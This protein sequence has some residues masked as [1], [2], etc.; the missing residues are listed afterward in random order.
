M[1]ITVRDLLDRGILDALAC[2]F[3]TEASR[4]ALLDQIGFPSNKRPVD[5]ADLDATGFWL[6]VCDLLEAGVVPLRLES[7]LR[8]VADVFHDLVDPTGVCR[9]TDPQRIEPV[10]EFDGWAFLPTSGV[11]RAEVRAEEITSLHDAA[12]V[13]TSG[14]GFSYAFYSKAADNV[15]PATAH[16]EELAGARPEAAEDLPAPRY[17]NAQMPQRI[18]RN[19]WVALWARVALGVQPA[20]AALL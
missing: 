17:L 7:L 12:P 16:P 15:P 8:A 5:D 2:L 14:A 6:A 11:K 19:Q 9:T 20:Q 10:D 3:P 1:A 18:R 4:S 13:D